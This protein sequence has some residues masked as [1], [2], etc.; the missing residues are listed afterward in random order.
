MKPGRN[1][2]CPCGSGRKY[3]HCCWSTAQAI[4]PED[5][6]WRRARRALESIGHDL[7][8]EA[9]RC[10]G[11]VGIDGA[12]EEFHLVGAELPFDP[13]SHNMPMFMSWFLY[14]WLPGAGVGSETPADTREHTAAQA[15]LLRA[16]SRIDPI[17]R[18]Y[19]EAACNSPFGFYEVVACRPGHGFRLSDVLLGSEV[20]VIEHSASNQ[21]Q[22]GDIMFAK[23]VSVDGITLVEGIG[24]ALIP[25]Q[26]KPELI[27]LRNALAA[28]SHASG[29]QLLHD[30][31]DE[32]REQYLVMADAIL[33][34]QLPELRN[35]DD[36][37]LQ[38]HTL[39][40]DLDAPQAAFEALKDLSAGFDEPQIERDATGAFIGARISWTRKGNKTQKDWDN[41]ILGSI[42]IKGQR[43]TAE[44]NSS[45]RAAKLTKL[46]AQRLGDSARA[47][48]SVVQSVQSALT[49]TPTS[50][51]AAARKRHQDQQAVFAAQPEVQAAVREHLR[52]HYRSW[53]DQKIPA[54]G[55]RT[56]RAAVRDADGREAVSALILQ[57]ERDGTR[58]SL[59]LDSEIMRELRQSLGLA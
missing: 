59:P 27:E 13:Q 31:S 25:P 17:A 22:I 10:F 20:E 21:A 44:V 28:Q 47:K 40:F 19:I 45:K 39:I 35:T 12:W 1:E 15:F 7:T 9:L 48:P 14:H 49:R 23:L 36:D 3:K 46:I 56:P 43:L 16:G 18:R 30:H 51:E 5:L 53:I 11:E 4:A 6:T 32:I 37:P 29:V 26:F 42:R 33:N 54:L 50:Q 57:I 2:P 34:P 8:S 24:P 52:K 55:N 41:T 58:M 38:M